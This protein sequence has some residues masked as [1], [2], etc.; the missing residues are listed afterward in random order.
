MFLVVEPGGVADI[1]VSLQQAAVIAEHG[2]EAL[3]GAAGEP[4][5][6]HPDPRGMI[7]PQVSI[8][9]VVL[10]GV[11]V[12]YEG[13]VGL[14]IS[15]RAD[16]IAQGFIDE[17]KPVHDQVH[18]SAH[19]LAADLDVMALLEDLL[20]PIE[21]KMV[22]VFS[23]NN[24]ED[25]PRR[26]IGA[27]DELGG[28]SRGDDRHHGAVGDLFVFWANGDPL[29]ETRRRHIEL[30]RALFADLFPLIRILQHFV[31]LDHND[32]LREPKS[33]MPAIPRKN[34]HSTTRSGWTHSELRSRSMA[35]CSMSL[36][37]ILKRSGSS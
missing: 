28:G 36:F 4:F 31:R 27:F 24:V 21:R 8:G 32:L 16:F 15:A 6:Q 5:K 37:S 33:S 29:E 7:D 23:K 22:A 14:D 25:K 13:F 35:R 26:G 1:A 9:T 19:R 30:L 10:F 18:P 2:A 3:C 17:R 11:L 12:F 20:L 34:L